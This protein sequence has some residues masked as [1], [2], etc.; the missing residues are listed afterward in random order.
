MA[1]IVIL[2]TTNYDKVKGFFEHNIKLA[3]AWTNIVQKC[4]T[5]SDFERFNTRL[6]LILVFAFEG[7]SKT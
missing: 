4:S 6:L 5:W 2:H 3:R 7:E 1:K